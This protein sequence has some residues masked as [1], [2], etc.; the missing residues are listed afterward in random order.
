M[1]RGKV[2]SLKQAVIQLELVGR[3]G[4][5]MLIDAVV[6][7]GF[8]GHLTI[9]VNVAKSSDLQIRETRE[10]QLGNGSLEEFLV[11]DANLLWD[12]SPRRVGALATDGPTLVGMS[13]LQ[14]CTIYIDAVDGCIVEITNR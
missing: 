1:I 12:I 11:Y 6:D 13:M 4:N 7:T 9:P 2:T 8:N 10:Y 5:A 3:N 14:G